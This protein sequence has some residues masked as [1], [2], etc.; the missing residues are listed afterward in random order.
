MK[1]EST[2]RVFRTL[3]RFIF[4]EITIFFSSASSSAFSVS[5]QRRG[6]GAEAWLKVS[7]NKQENE[8]FPSNMVDEPDFYISYQM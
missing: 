4:F 7:G 3:N 5:R 8:G 6:A 2:A 1:Q